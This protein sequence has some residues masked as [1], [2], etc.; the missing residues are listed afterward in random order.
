MLRVCQESGLLWIM[1]R[2]QGKQRAW[3]LLTVS[4]KRPRTQPGNDITWANGNI[5]RCWRLKKKCLVFVLSKK[6]HLFNDYNIYEKSTHLF[7]IDL[8]IPPYGRVEFNFNM[9][10]ASSWRVRCFDGAS[11]E[12]MMLI[13]CKYFWQSSL[14]PMNVQTR[15]DKL[16]RTSAP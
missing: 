6:P 10:L 8:K 4:P 16:K 2:Y 5:S 11:P 1:R 9:I 13:G 7:Y 3:W 12:T 15:A 14:V